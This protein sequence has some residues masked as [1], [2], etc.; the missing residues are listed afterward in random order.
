T[1]GNGTTARADGAVPT[2]H[3]ANGEP[4]MSPSAAALDAATRARA[5]GA[6]DETLRHAERAAAAGADPAAVA[7]LRAVACTHLA[8]LDEAEAQFAALL[9]STGYRQRGETGLGIVALQ[10]GDD[11]TARA[12]L[13][14]AT[15]AS[16]TADAWAALGLC[17]ARLAQT[18]D[19][20]RAYVE[21]RS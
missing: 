16:G 2:A 3:V 1:N 8:R 15:A 21:A 6:W 7:E 9:G 19:A 11:A 13:E 17:R 20:W 4:S 5:A 14:R 18:E 10:R 12:W